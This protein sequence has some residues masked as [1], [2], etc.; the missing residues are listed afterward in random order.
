[1]TRESDNEIVFKKN[2]EII[3]NLVKLKD[4]SSIKKYL[5]EKKLN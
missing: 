5:H 3:K 2:E 1:M 4:I